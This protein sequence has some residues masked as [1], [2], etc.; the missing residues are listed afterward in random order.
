MDTNVERDFDEIVHG[1]AGERVMIIG[2]EQ[3]LITD[4]AVVNPR[5][6]EGHMVSAV[7]RDDE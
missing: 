1:E 2:Q 5:V 3:K 6:G 7:I 4:E